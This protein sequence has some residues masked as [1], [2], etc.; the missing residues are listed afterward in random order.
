MKRFLF[1]TFFIYAVFNITAGQDSSYIRNR[2]NIKVGYARYS[3]GTKVNDK[4]QKTGNLFLEGNYGILN[5]LETGIYMGYS[6]FEFYSVDVNGTSYSSENYFTP[7]YGINANFHVLPFI[8]KESD[9]RFDLY[10]AVKY[11]GKYFTTPANAS[12]HG[13]KSE[14]GLGLGFSFYLFNHIGLY[15]EYGYGKYHFREVKKDNT[16]FRYGLTFKF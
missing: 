13:H 3:S 12:P 1:I 16:K 9:F 4:W 7:F 2:W 14:Y 10:L 15:A 11:G 6:C 5:F 8:I